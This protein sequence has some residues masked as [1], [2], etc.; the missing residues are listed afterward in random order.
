MTVLL[1]RARL[2][3]ETEGLRA[4]LRRALSLLLRWFFEYETYYLYY[5]PTEQVALMN[6][7]ELV[8]QVADLALR[9]VSTNAEA[10]EVEAEG[11]RFRP[12]ASHMRRKF[13]AGAVG[14]CIFVGHELANLSW[15]AMSER[16]RCSLGEPPMWVDFAQREAYRGG[17]WTNPRYRRM[18]LSQYSLYKK[19]EYMQD[20]GIVRSRVLIAKR[21]TASQKGH[22][23]FGPIR[24]GEGRLLRVLRVTSWR[25][26][27]LTPD[28]SFSNDAPATPP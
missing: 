17:I 2:I 12:Y 25:E 11:L 9:V 18:G 28:E 8:P 1:L 26:K 24:Y 7:A 19:L 5:Q 16:A 14:F 4:T 20:R 6:R 3:L 15:L 27:T 13:A 22:A 10:D 23:R 21:N